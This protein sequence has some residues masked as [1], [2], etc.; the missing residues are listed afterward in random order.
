MKKKLKHNKQINLFETEEPQA[1]SSGSNK[2]KSVF[3]NSDKN[4]KH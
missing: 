3:K 4:I 1:K 2:G